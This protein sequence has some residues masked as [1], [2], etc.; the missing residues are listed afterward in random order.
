M[1]IGARGVCGVPG[2]QC[3]SEKTSRD[4]ETSCYAD[5]Q[6]RHMMEGLN[7]MGEYSTHIVSLVKAAEL[8][9]SMI[10]L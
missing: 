9:I 10:S 1:L 8:S 3:S 6:R 4:S 7:N 2:K 5:G